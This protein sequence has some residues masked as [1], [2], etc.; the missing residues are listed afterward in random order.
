VFCQYC[1]KEILA[2]AGFCPTCGKMVP[3]ENASPAT[4]AQQGGAKPQD[5]AK[6]NEFDISQSPLASS[7]LAKWGKRIGL[8]LA[9]FI[10]YMVILDD[11]LNARD[12]EVFLASL[13]AT[14]ITYFLALRI[15]KKIN[16]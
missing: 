3:Q 11:V 15:A 12:E 5:G 16:I 1:G 9:A 7:G 14:V 2:E 8:T 13:A 10:L 6:P 4:P